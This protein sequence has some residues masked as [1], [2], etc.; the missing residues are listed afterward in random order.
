MPN[1]C[2]CSLSLPGVPVAAARRTLADVWARYSE[3]NERS[4]NAM[5][6]FNKIHPCPPGLSE[7]ADPA[8]LFGESPARKWVSANW[9]T[10][11][12]GFYA[13]LRDGSDQTTWPF[14]EPSLFVDC[15][16]S[17]CDGIVRE[18]S[19][20]YPAVPWLVEWSEEQGPGPGGG[21]V[22]Y[23]LYRRGKE[24]AH[25]M[26]DQW[27]DV[28]LCRSTLITPRHGA[29]FRASRSC[30]GCGADG[31]GLRCSRCK[32]AFYCSRACQAAAWTQGH[33]RACPRLAAKA[34]EDLRQS[35]RIPPICAEGLPPHF[36]RPWS[37]EAHKRADAPT[38]ARVLRLLA[39]GQ[40]LTARGA[41]TKDV[42]VR[43]ILPL[44]V[45]LAPPRK[46]GNGDIDRHVRAYTGSVAEHW[47][48]DD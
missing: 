32:S 41:M 20:Q 15:K 47:H 21:F 39:V 37:V 27:T 31:A 4:G 14:P 1:W 13:E 7:E 11:A 42:W 26:V 46:M 19:R 23:A 12:W 16:W 45:G 43:V 9:G 40:A 18:L 10:C 44:A 38:R 24:L 36:L 30:D 6:N 29:P 28:S 5:I 33:K 34:V 3:T 17:P 2:S 25:V 22:G 48:F 35:A 8:Q